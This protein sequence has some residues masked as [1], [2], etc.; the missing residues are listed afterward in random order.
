MTNE[1][2]EVKPTVEQ[3]A[4]E[5]KVKKEREISKFLTDEKR[6]AIIEQLRE[7]NIDSTDLNDE[8]LLDALMNK[9]K[10]LSKKA[11]KPDEAE[12]LATRL[13]AYAKA[14]EKSLLNDKKFIARLRDMAIRPNYLHLFRDHDANLSDKKIWERIRYSGVMHHKNDL[15]EVLSRKY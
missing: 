2:K 11:V 13:T 15:S 5:K 6:N 3:K 12:E 14:N 4:E 1:I 8:E 9:A 7:L 10:I